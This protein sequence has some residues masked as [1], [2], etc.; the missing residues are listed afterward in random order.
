MYELVCM[1]V[2]CGYS[3][4]SK[5]A[6]RTDVNWASE[7]LSQNEQLLQTYIA[8]ETD[9]AYATAVIGKWHLSGNDA[10]VNPEDL[11]IDYYAGLIR[12]LVQDR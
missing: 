12:G 8:E 9:D 4:T 11:G 7:P 10:D 2:L 1:L 6:Y 3:I 5:Y